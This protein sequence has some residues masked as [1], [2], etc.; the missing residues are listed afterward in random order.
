MQRKVAKRK[1]VREAAFD[2]ERGQCLIISIASLGTGLDRVIVQRDRRG[3]VRVRA[4]NGPG[5][6]RFEFSDKKIGPNACD[7][8][9]ARADSQTSIVDMLR[10]RFWGQFTWA[11]TD[12][13]RKNQRLQ[14]RLTS[15][16][17][18]IAEEMEANAAKRLNRMLT[19][20]CFRRKSR[21]K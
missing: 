3:R 9:L 18:M 2:L 8:W 1:L 16:L 19:L 7:F 6:G 13:L 14:G 15:A 4:M 17:R 11:E 21:K 20:S 12:K 5:G 10:S